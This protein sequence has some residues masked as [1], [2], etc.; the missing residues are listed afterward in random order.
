[1]AAVIGVGPAVVV[2]GIGAVAVAAVGWRL[3]P[4]LVRVER[5]DR[6]L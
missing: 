1:M 6:A 3:F 4:D 2:G 5:M